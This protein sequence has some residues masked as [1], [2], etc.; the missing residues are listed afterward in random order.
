MCQAGQAG[1]RKGSKISTSLRFKGTLCAF[2]RYGIAEGVGAAPGS[3]SCVALM[4]LIK[5]FNGTNIHV[6][7]A[8]SLA[9]RARLLRAAGDDTAISSRK[10]VLASMEQGYT[11]HD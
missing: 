1:W 4:E 6:S 5:C 11:E 8:A 2:P 7:A 10:H 3:S 9:A